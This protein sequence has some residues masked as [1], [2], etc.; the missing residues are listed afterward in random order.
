[1]F[2]QL[3]LPTQR[4][5]KLWYLHGR[6]AVVYFVDAV[7]G[8]ASSEDGGENFEAH[9]KEVGP[10]RWSDGVRVNVVALVGACGVARIEDH[11]H[12]HAWN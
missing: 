5:L 8:S 12:E 4:R 3:K 6:R 9:G 10:W 7:A 11:L 1:M 2:W